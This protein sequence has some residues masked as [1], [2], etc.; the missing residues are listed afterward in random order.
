[1]M[2]LVVIGSYDKQ[3]GKNGGREGRG[4]EGVDGKKWGGNERKLVEIEKGRDT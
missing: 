3:V 2:T 1:M 4:G